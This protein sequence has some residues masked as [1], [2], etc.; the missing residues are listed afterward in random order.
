[1]A[2][3]LL[4][5]IEEP[6][7]LRKLTQSQLP[8]ITEELRSELIAI[9]AEKGGHFAGSDIVGHQNSRDGCEQDTVAV[10]A[11]GDGEMVQGHGAEDRFAV[12]RHGT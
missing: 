6:A 11:G 9:G 7:Q 4:A 12:F 3:P 5:S 1:M 8:V 2:T 10:V